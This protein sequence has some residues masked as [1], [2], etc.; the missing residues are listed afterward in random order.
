MKRFVFCLVLSLGFLIQHTGVA[1]I[2]LDHEATPGD[3]CK[4]GDL[5]FSNFDYPSHVARC[6]RHVTKGMKQQVADYYEV[7]EEDWSNYEFDHL[8]PLCAGGSNH[9]EN[10]W[11]EP[12]EL[13]LEK[14]KIE[15]KICRALKA[16]T[17]DQEEAI[18]EIDDWFEEKGF[19][20]SQ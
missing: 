16:G 6:T 9:I 20:T 11:P 7:V 19:S 10:L 5:D 17:M 18:Q 2:V 12:K 1:D 13:A 14:D 15:N 4:E 3:L 8:Y